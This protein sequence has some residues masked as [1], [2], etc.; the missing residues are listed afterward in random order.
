M[1]MRFELEALCKFDC[2]VRMVLDTHHVHDG[3]NSFYLTRQAA[4][5][6]AY[7][8]LTEMLSHV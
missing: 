5:S 6:E 8:L 7:H 3:S 2:E 1:I 4:V